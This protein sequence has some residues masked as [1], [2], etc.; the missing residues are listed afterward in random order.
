M[1]G[2]KHTVG[3]YRR[4]GTN[5][6]LRFYVG[7]D[8]FKVSLGFPTPPPKQIYLFLSSVK[9]AIILGKAILSKGKRYTIDSLV[10]HSRPFSIWVFLVLVFVSICLLFVVWIA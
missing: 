3:R 10:L 6:T 9:L 4:Y 1:A 5:I 7:T 8:G 2:L